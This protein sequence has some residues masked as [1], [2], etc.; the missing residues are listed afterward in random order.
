MAYHCG[1]IGPKHFNGQSAL[2][3]DAKMLKELE[4]RLKLLRFINLQFSW[5][6]HL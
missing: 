2:S 4:V 5:P 6:Q 3:F 1:S